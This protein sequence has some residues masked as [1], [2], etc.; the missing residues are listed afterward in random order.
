MRILL[1]TCVD[2]LA[3][4]IFVRITKIFGHVVLFLTIIQILVHFLQLIHKIVNKWFPI[5]LNLHTICWYA[6]I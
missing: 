4:K 3:L 5:D 1:D 6:S 2:R